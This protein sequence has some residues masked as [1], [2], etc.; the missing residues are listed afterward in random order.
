MPI[1]IIPNDYGLSKTQTQMY[2]TID[3]NERINQTIE[4]MQHEEEEEEEE[5]EEEED[6]LKDIST[7]AGTDPVLLEEELHDREKPPLLE[8]VVETTEKKRGEE[9]KLQEEEIAQML[10]RPNVT[11]FSPNRDGK[12]DDFGGVPSICS[13]WD[14]Q[15]QQ[16][17]GNGAN[18]IGGILFKNDNWMCGSRSIGNKL[19]LYF[20][21]RTFAELHGVSF[22]IHP[23]CSKGENYDNLI[24]WLPQNVLVNNIVNNKNANVNNN[25]H[26]DN[27]PN[28]MV[29]PTFNRTTEWFTKTRKAM[30]NCGRP[31]THQCEEGWPSLSNR[32][33]Y[34]IR[35]ALQDWAS[36][37]SSASSNEI[38]S[39]SPTTIEKGSTG[40]V[41]TIH[42]RCG[43]ILNPATAG[44]GGMG[45]LKPSFYYKHLKGRNI[46]SVH[47]LTTPL[48]GCNK[49]TT[50][51][52]QD[53]EYGPS[54][55][56]IIDALIGRLSSLMNLSKDSFKIYDHESSMWSMHHIVFSDVTF[57]SPS[58]FCLFS[59][60]GSN[61]AVHTAS[62][63]KFPAIQKTVA[64]ALNHTF[65]YD[66]DGGHDYLIDVNAMP[67]NGTVERIIELMM[68]DA[69]I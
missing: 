43:D 41:A 20:Q 48:N 59:S 21:A 63:N 4:I 39:T 62:E 30:C 45:F 56:Q 64:R 3:S 16:S 46:T 11:Y 65:E 28:G 10:S 5:N 31:I 58:T 60:L 69:M 50:E 9:E 61:H 7:A 15:Q 34:E 8:L 2:H 68:E 53:C 23:P 17:N 26:H 57:C 55:A 29:V 47:I 22:H 32:W 1:P 54:C 49:G 33:H 6:I 25:R 51:R 40:I 52:K 27:N 14:Q 13:S 42:F 19:G 44:T 66:N 12:Y 35:S 38:T 67:T 37:S 36:S 24:A 18:E